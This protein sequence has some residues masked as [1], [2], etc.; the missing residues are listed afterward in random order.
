[1]TKFAYLGLCLLLPPLGYVLGGML[2]RPAMHVGYVLIWGLAGYVDL[3]EHRIPNWLTW[4][5][6][7]LTLGA[8]FHLSGW[9]SG[10]L[11]GLVGAMLF[12]IPVLW[13]GPERAG[14]GDVK[15]AALVGLVLGLSVSLYWALLIAFTTAALV[16]LV[17]IV[18]GKMTRQSLLPFGFFLA[19]GASVSLLLGF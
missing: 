19:L 13:Y 18:L 12:L 8:T 15:L 14:L 3:R 1:M 17:G 16:G 9:V 11:G 6:I 2:S 4:P 5:G 10:L 7:L